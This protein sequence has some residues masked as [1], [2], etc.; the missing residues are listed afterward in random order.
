M[1]RNLISLGAIDVYG[2]KYTGSLR[3]PKVSKGSLIHG[4]GD[5]NSTKLYVLRSSTFPGIDVVV[6][7][8]ENGKTNLWYMHLAYISEHGMT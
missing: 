4:I 5:M 2:Y 1:A 6:S 8:D 7:V 3:L